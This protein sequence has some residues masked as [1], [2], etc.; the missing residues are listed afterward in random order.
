MHGRMLAGLV[1]ASLTLAAP[2]LA[3]AD[4]MPPGDYTVRLGPGSLKFGELPPV[5]MSSLPPLEVALADQPVTAPLPVPYTLTIAP[6]PG[7]TI[8]TTIDQGQAT[9][10]PAT[11]AITS[12]ISLH[13]VLKAVP[14][15]FLNVSGTCT[16]GAIDNQIPMR[17]ATTPD[18][19]W[20]LPD[21]SF[22]V[23]DNS[24]GL[25]TAVCDDPTLQSL[26]VNAAGDTS[27]GHNSA[28]IAG[29]AAR[30]ED[31]PPPEPP[32]PV[33][34]SG[35]GSGGGGTS[36]PSSPISGG[37]PGSDSTAAPTGG[38]NDAAATAPRCVVPRL[39]GRTL[40]AAKRALKRA[41]CRLGKVSKRR[42][43]RRRGTVL[44]QSRAPGRRLPR[45]TRVAITLARH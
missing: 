7:I 34:D 6:I 36:P 39:K 20:K 43:H 29:T 11:G 38:S 8:T 13:A 22:T 26:V 27:A 28:A 2:S 37:E 35:S 17:L 45:G 9:I 23:Y 12:D 21:R 41:G 24:Y 3:T 16:Y 31:A 42:A 44:T 15:A 30:P 5:A 25:P 32:A 4:P 18:S 14:S 40:T 1:A 19:V 33:I 10:D